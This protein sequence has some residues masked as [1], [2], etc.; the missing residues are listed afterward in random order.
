VSWLDALSGS[1]SAPRPVPGANGDGGPAVGG[2]HE[3]RAGDDFNERADWADILQPLGAVL[4]HESGGERYWTRPG[5]DRRDGPS[6][7]TG[8]ADDADRL[9]VFSTHWPP[10]ADGEVYTKFGAYALLNHGGDHQAAARELS[11]RGYGSQRPAQAPPA[12]PTRN[13][14]PE[15]G[16]HPAG[17]VQAGGSSALAP[18]VKIGGRQRSEPLTELGFARRLVDKHGDEL[19]YVV[20]WNRWLVWDDTRW[21]PD[22]DGHVQRCMKVIAR[23]VHTALIRGNAAPE[24]IRAAKRAE[25]S[26]AV[27]GALILAATEPEIAITPDRLDAHPYLLNCRNGVVDL[28]TGELLDH[29]PALLLTKVAGARYEPDAEGAVFTGFLARIQPSE[30]MRLF[31]R[32]LLGLSLEGTVTAH[33]LPI[34]YGDG[35]NGKSTLTDAVMTALGDYADAADP[36][37]LRARTFDAHPTGVA[38]LFG[39]RLAVLHES[40]AGHRLAEGTVKRLTGGDRLKA[41]RMREDFWS[42]D[43]SHTFVMLTNHKPGV[44]GTDEGIWRRLR[45]VPFEVIIPGSERDED[46]G[47]KLADEAGAI[48]AWLVAGHLEWR[49]NGLAEPGKVTEATRAYR[50]ESDPLG[51]FIS[52]RCLCMPAMRAGS[53]ELFKAFEQWCAAEREDP[54]TPTAFGNAMKAKGFESHKSNGRML[55]HGIGLADDDSGEGGEGLCQYSRARIAQTLQR[56]L[57]SPDLPVIR[58]YTGKSGIGQGG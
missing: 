56:S 48:L 29:D 4:H 17:Q 40:D 46:L 26:S 43:P 58:S 16:P 5:K 10:F 22:V 21:A 54:G 18:V 49:K 32:R 8:Y 23:E 52:E 14:P 36:D 55:W 13:R 53:S 24:V 35:A 41:R 15:M 38:D 20:P 1:R 31:I 42:F 50:A 27:K 37:L 3:G 39:L 34:F 6:A 30:Q 33:I 44:S 7:T 51:R 9:K 28:Q 25:S 45:L 2:R 12:E 11:R 19:R 57:P 47:G